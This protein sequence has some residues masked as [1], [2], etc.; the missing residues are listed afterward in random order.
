MQ[1]EPFINGAWVAPVAGGTLPVTCPA[2]EAVVHHV[3]AATAPDADAAVKAAR[4]AFDYGPW[5]H[6]T[7]ANRARIIWITCSQ[8]RFTEAPRGGM[9]Q[10]GFGRKHGRWGRDNCLETRQ[11]TSWQLK[12]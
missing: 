5:P 11:I 1:T 9:K 7:G 2:T 10:S 4:A 3:P 8:P 12:A 6:M